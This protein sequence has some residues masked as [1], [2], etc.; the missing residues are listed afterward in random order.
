MS[1]SGPKTG[2][3]GAWLIYPLGVCLLIVA[4]PI[5]A[6]ER[7]IEPN[8]HLATTALRLLKQA[9][10]ID[11][12]A[13]HSTSSTNPALDHFYAAKVVEIDRLIDDLEHGHSVSLKAVDEALDNQGAR[14][15]GPGSVW[16]APEKHSW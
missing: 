14:G 2:R 7:R 15:L 6:Q 1:L 16:T 13:A 5:A 8:T 11:Q 12:M 9:R 4:A 3:V 10:S